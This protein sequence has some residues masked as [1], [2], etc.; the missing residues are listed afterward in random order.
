VSA[1]ALARWLRRRGATVRTVASRVGMSDSTLRDWQRRW[2]A[3]RMVIRPR[4]RPAE[5]ADR[6]LRRA[7]LSVFALMGPQLGLPTLRELFPEASRGELV[8]LQRRCRRAW[9]RGRRVRACAS[10]E[11]PRAGLGDRSH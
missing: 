9:L 4:G 6:D 1:V 5:H 7:I 10:L 3:N 2:R 11:A 8:E